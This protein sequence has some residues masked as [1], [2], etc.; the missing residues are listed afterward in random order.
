MMAQKLQRHQTFASLEQNPF[1]ETFV[2]LEISK[3]YPHHNKLVNE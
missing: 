1:V 3:C 2:N